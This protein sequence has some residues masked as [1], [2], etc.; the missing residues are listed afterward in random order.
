[1]A[2][3]L[4]M[5]KYAKFE[6]SRRCDFCKRPVKAGY[7]VN[8]GPTHGFFCSGHHYRDAVEH[9]KQEKDKRGIE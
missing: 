6:H 4:V 5:G 2:E 9:M 7:F 1:M 8:T 3:G